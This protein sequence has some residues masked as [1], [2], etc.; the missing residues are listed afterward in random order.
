[1]R[2]SIQNFDPDYY[3]VQAKYDRAVIFYRLKMVHR[4]LEILNDL[5][6]DPQF[7][8][9]TKNPPEGYFSS[10][11]GRQVY[12]EFS[13]LFEKLLF[14]KGDKKWKSVQDE[15]IRRFGFYNQKPADLYSSEYLSSAMRLASRARD[16]DR[17]KSICELRLK[18]HERI[19]AE[20]NIALPPV[21]PSILYENSYIYAFTVGQEDMSRRNRYY[22]AES[23]DNCG[24]VYEIN[25]KFSEA[26]GYLQTAYALGLMTDG[27]EFIFESSVS[28][29]IANLIAKIGNIKSSLEYL[30]KSISAYD[31][32]NQYGFTMKTFCENHIAS[33]DGNDIRVVLHKI[34]ET[35]N[36]LLKAGCEVR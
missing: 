16:F 9:Y 32:P 23:N 5:F 6:V 36:L 2:R 22:I 18:W 3:L 7:V 26:L 28:Y 35:R 19:W 1:M 4:A 11:I 34:P 8:E 14:Y 24:D 15:S 17:A 33:G 13:N 21:S 12:G 30:E 31:K 25:G 10:G 29:K 27:D 20:N